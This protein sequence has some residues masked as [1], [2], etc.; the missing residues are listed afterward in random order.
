MKNGF[1]KRHFFF[2]A[3]VLIALLSCNDDE[4]EVTGDLV[5]VWAGSDAEF[6][7]DPDGLVPAFTLNEDTIPVQL[8]FKADGAVFLTDNNG[9]RVSG[10]YGL[11]GRNLTLDIDYTYEFVELAGVYKVVELN[12]DRLTLQITKDG[13]YTDP[14]RNETYEGEV[15]ATMNF[16]KQGSN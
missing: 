5:G 6:R 15:E 11:S 3:L 9:A 10:T 12:G 16:I 14:D 2:F 7:L 1:M 13:S 4:G 8:D